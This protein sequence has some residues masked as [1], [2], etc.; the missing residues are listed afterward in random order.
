MKSLGTLFIS[1][2]I[3]LALLSFNSSESSK[4]LGTY[5]VS[6]DD[7]SGIKLKLNEDHTFH[8]T[9]YSNIAKAINATGKWE[10]VDRTVYLKGFKSNHSF[11]T[12]WKMSK[13]GKIATS[14][15]GISFY[16]LKKLD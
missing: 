8:Y 3:I 12:K 11:H 5:G 7:P 1:T 10:M 9:D 14:R 16:A 13:N 15:L 4:F 2:I 6:K